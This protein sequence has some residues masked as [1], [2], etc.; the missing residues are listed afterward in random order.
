MEEPA[1]WPRQ[2]FPN[3]IKQLNNT[4][5]IPTRERSETGAISTFTTNADVHDFGCRSAEALRMK[6]HSKNFV[7]PTSDRRERQ[8]ESLSKIHRSQRVQPSPEG[9]TENSPAFQR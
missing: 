8:E 4:L 9:P 6:A 1:V 7:I 2:A 5:V 3:P